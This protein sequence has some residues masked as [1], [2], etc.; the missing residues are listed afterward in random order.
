MFF[1]II[2]N[3]S[4]SNTLFHNIRNCQ[5]PP[6]SQPS[7]PDSQPCLHYFFLLVG[8]D[9]GLRAAKVFPFFF[10]NLLVHLCIQCFRRLLRTASDTRLYANAKGNEHHRVILICAFIPEPILVLGVLMAWCTTSRNML[11][12]IGSS[13]P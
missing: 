2:S 11:Q 5:Q 12:W 9:A 4:S 3:K 13:D 6:M 7:V 10:C 8:M 1:L